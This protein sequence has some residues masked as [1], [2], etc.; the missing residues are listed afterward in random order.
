MSGIASARL[1]EERKAWRK[2]HPFVRGC[3]LHYVSLDQLVFLK[4][5]ALMFQ[6]FVARPMKN[7][8]GSLNLMTWECAIPGKKGVSAT[9]NCLLHSD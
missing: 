1:A 2:D 9:E 7:P 4:L 6:G 5:I 3:F 8:D